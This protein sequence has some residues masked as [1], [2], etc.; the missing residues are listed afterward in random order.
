MT[1][2][3]ESERVLIFCG[4]CREV[5]KHWT[6]PVASIVVDPPHLGADYLHSLRDGFRAWRPDDMAH[7]MTMQLAFFQ[8]WIPPCHQ[9]VGEG[10]M[11]VHLPLHQMFP[12][13]ST[14]YWDRWQ[15]QQAWQLNPEEALLCLCQSG[16]ITAEAV[17][18]IRAEQDRNKYN[19]P[20][21][22]EWIDVL[23][24][25]SPDGPVF[26]PMMGTGSTLLAALALGRPAI[27]I[28]LR[29][30]LCRQTVAR[31]QEAEQ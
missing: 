30:D 26:D 24:K 25:L 13:Q 8:A 19:Q 29:E 23:L 4:D 10:P 18:T 9:M 16:H 22:I 12:F 31:I 7:W 1:P 5:L 15:A 11:W 2:F 20:K 14:A 21:P 27:G 17:A 6:M 28:E 3:Y